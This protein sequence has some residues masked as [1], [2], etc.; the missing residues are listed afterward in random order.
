[1]LW[2]VCAYVMAGISYAHI[3]YLP[4]A[5]STEWRHCAKRTGR[6]KKDWRGEINNFISTVQASRYYL[7][8]SYVVYARTVQDDNNGVLRRYTRR[9]RWRLCFILYTYVHRTQ[10]IRHA[11]WRSQCI[12]WLILVPVQL[13]GLPTTHT[14]NAQLV[15]IS[16]S[17][18]RK[19]SLI[20]ST[21]PDTASNYQVIK[22]EG[23]PNIVRT[24]M[25]RPL[26]VTC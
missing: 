6:V 13:A 18:E 19:H 10:W 9:R 11:W 23:G 26:Y 21:L 15:L 20:A 8:W 17:H 1:M 14:W 7:V 3:I 4:E 12:A 24:Y 16:K 2:F 25:R 22:V 5:A